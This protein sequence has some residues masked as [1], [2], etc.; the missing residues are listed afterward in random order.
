[1]LVSY[2]IFT[3]DYNL[4]VKTVKIYIKQLCYG[5]GMYIS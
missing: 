1:M 3:L 5:I 2:N 4:K